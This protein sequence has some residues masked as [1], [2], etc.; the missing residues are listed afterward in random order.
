M[1]ELKAT[2]M[3]PFA[4]PSALKIGQQCNMVEFETEVLPGLV[5]LM[6]V[7]DPIQVRWPQT[8]PKRLTSL[9]FGDADRRMW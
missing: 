8:S 3:A 7:T 4:L 6:A 5:P 2:V 1:N 9:V